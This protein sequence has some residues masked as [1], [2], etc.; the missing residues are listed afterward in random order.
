V[1]AAPPGRGPAT[2][3]PIARVRVRVHGRVQGVFFRDT[4]RRR[5][6]SRGVAG[7]VANRGDGTVEAALEGRRADVEALLGFCRQGPARA[8]VERVEVRDEEP[9]GLTEFKIE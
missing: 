3:P 2:G 4:L 9:E 5:A 6:E 7:W 8:E 1:T